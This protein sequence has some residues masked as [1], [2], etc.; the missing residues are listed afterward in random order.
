MQVRICALS[1]FLF[2]LNLHSGSTTVSLKQSTHWYQFEPGSFLLD[3]S[4]NGNTLTAST[5]A[6]TVA[7]SG[8]AVGG[9]C[10][11]LSN[12]GLTGNDASAQY[13]AIPTIDFGEYSSTGISISVWFKVSSYQQGM[14]LWDFNNGAD[15]LDTF[16]LSFGGPNILQ[17][18][19]SV[20]NVVLDTTCYP[21]L[22]TTR[23]WR[24]AVMSVTTDGVF[25]HYLDGLFLGQG[26]VGLPS[27]T[28]NGDYNF[29]GRSSTAADYVIDGE[30]DDLRIYADVLQLTDVVELWRMGQSLQLTHHYAFETAAMT[31]DSSGSGNTLVAVNNPTYLTS[32]CK[33]GNGCA[34]LDNAGLKARTTNSHFRVPALNFAE[35]ADDGISFR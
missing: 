13:F 19:E 31:V 7:T 21:S 26:Q 2:S 30:V 1:V 18:K 22:S 29:I 4:G 34:F 28:R 9:G 10:A 24:H 14:R 12:N 16:Y 11:S 23:T 25:R 33:V 6:P 17:G 20:A 35:Y 5:V 3:S 32:G 8:C 27:G 15:G